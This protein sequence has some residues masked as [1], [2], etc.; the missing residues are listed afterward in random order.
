MDTT[1]VG[2]Y[3]SVHMGLTFNMDTFNKLFQF[4]KNFKNSV[5]LVYDLIKSNYGLNPIHVYRLSGKIIDILED[6]SLLL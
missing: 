2:F 1:K 4:Y 3:M 6:K 5:V